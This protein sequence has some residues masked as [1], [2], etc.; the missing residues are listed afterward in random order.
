MANSVIQLRSDDVV[1]LKD[2]KEELLIK[3]RA[4]LVHEQ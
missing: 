1:N 4:E 3:L 2:L